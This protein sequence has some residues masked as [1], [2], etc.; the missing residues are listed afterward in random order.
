MAAEDLEPECPEREL[1]VEERLDLPTRRR[2]TRDRVAWDQWKEDADRETAAVDRERRREIGRIAGKI[3]RSDD[4]A[5]HQ[6]READGPSESARDV[7]V[8]VDEAGKH[9]EAGSIEDQSCTAPVRSGATSDDPSALEREVC[10]SRP[11]RPAPTGKEPRDDQTPEAHLVD[12]R[13]LDA[14]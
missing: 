2:G 13:R 10:C 3:E 12:R 5:A 7:D 1:R 9:V 8:R 11:T 4:A 14:D 6:H